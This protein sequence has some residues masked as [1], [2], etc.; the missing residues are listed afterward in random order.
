MFDVIARMAIGLPL[1]LLFCPAAPAEDDL[2]SRDWNAASRASLEASPPAA[3]EVE[4]FLDRLLNEHPFYKNSVYGSDDKGHF[5]TLKNGN[6]I[7]GYKFL[8]LPVYREPFY[9]LLVLIGASS[10]PSCHGILV[11][12][13]QQNKTFII[14]E[15]QVSPFIHWPM[16]INNIVQNINEDGTPA[17]VFDEVAYSGNH[18]ADDCVATWPALYKWLNYAGQFG[19]DDRYFRKYNETLLKKLEAATP[20]KTNAPCVQMERDRMSRLLGAPANAGFERALEWVKSKDPKLRLKAVMV[21]QD[22]RD[23]Q[24]IEQLSALKNDPDPVIA[25]LI[26]AILEPVTF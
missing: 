22:I 2:Y 9:N 5:I 16:D 10:A 18:Y 17:L 13:K 19:H 1:M 25:G 24:S 4:R 8:K 7:C 14:Y 15:V 21:F 3:Q 6:K 23:K 12:R 11:I 20:D 26:E